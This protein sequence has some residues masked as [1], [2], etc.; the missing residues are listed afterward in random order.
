VHARFALIVAS[1]VASI[2]ALGACSSKDK[3]EQPP[4]PPS[5]VHDAGVAVDGITTIGAYDPASG[6]HLDDDGAGHT[7][8]RPTAP[9]P[10]R[11]ID[12]ILRS[13]PPG[14]VVMVDNV[15]IGNTPTYWAGMADG[16][17]HTFSFELAGYAGQFYRFVPVT[18]GVIHVRLDLVTGE[19]DAGAPETPPP[20]P[21]P[22]AP[23]PT[24]IT[25]DAAV[26][27]VAPP[28][29]AF[30]PLAPD[31]AATGSDTFGPTP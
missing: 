10:G 9:R 6:R 17:E 4:A 7:L 24:M 8:A 25:P 23:P 30:V 12:V 3:P 16:R 28:D 31:G 21:P 27:K 14:A 5:V 26:P 20:A 2:V 15:P 29:A 19:A 22:V 11:P 1:M 13:T 18:G